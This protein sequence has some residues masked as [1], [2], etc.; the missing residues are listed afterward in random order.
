M[1]KKKRYL[2]KVTSIKIEPYLA[3]YVLAKFPVDH[4]TGGVKIPSSS[5]L[6]FA[7][8]ELMSKPRHGQDDADGNL[9]ISLPCR[10]GYDSIAWKDPAYYNH[11]S[12]S[13]AKS[14]ENVIRLMFNFELHRVLLENEEFGHE[15]R[16][17]DVIYDFIREYNLKSI[18]PDALLKNYYRYRNRIRP[19]KTRKYK[20]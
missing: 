9:M 20:K 11:L 6:Y 1:E 19:K 17:Q 18:T 12:R 4:K 3:E 8:W 10:R 2:K 15:R 5:D 7:I 14:I 16:N 13:A